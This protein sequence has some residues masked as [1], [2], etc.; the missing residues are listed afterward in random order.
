MTARASASSVIREVLSATATTFDGATR[1]ATSSWTRMKS[2][3]GLSGK[4][5]SGRWS[6]SWSVT[7]GM[8]TRTIACGVNPWISPSVTD[9]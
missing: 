9:E 4:I 8:C 5:R 2:G 3:R 1:P 7:P 6:K